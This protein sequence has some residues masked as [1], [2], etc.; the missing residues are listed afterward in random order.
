[1]EVV[2][3]EMLYTK[4]IIKQKLPEEDFRISIM[5]RHTLDDG[6]TPNEKIV[7]YDCFDSWFKILA[8]PDKLVG[9]FYRGELSRE[10]YN[11]KYLGYLRTEKVSKIVK[12]IAGLARKTN[13]TAECIEEN[14]NECHRNV[15][16]KEC[17]RYFP[18][19]EVR[20]L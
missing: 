13:I 1:M 17:Q 10:N 20:H 3:F 18:D 2:G 19:L 11:K 15:F 7:N 6:K 14:A 8:P 16:A 12:K 5:S 4:S 9:A